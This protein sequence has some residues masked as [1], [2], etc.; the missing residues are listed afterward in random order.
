ML[1]LEEIFNLTEKELDIKLKEY[2]DNT[3]YSNL[4]DKIDAL[5][6]ELYNNS[7]LNKEELKIVG[8]P[9]YDKIMELKPKNYDEFVIFYNEIN[10]KPDPI[11]E[12]DLLT[13][14]GKLNGRSVKYFFRKF[15]K[16]GRGATGSVYRVQNLE[17]GTFYACKIME[18][19]QKLRYDPRNKEIQIHSK[20]QHENV[21]KM[22]KEY[23]T[24]D[25]INVY[26]FMELCTEVTWD[27][28]IPVRRTLS[29]DEIRK[30]TIQLINGLKYIH[31]MG[32]IHRDI[33]PQ[34]LLFNSNMELKIIDFGLA[35]S[36]ED[37]QNTNYSNLVGSLNYMSPEMIAD[38]MKYDYKVDIWALGILLYR[39]I[40]GVTP[41]QLKKIIDIKN[42]ITQDIIYPP[43]FNISSNLKN[44]IENILQKDQNNR[45]SLSQIRDHIFF[46]IEIMVE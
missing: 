12:E 18:Y 46:N 5:I 7:L 29:E 28:L 27:S 26:L 2:N 33:K 4:S 13:V 43:N 21:I 1:T 16:L 38:T 11:P 6:I 25:K 34:N 42:I 36:E 45:L 10:K 37:L 35:I 17:T 23:T 32:I 3:K 41:F 31:S 22:Y 44:L 9:N 14:P 8:N 39:S 30:Y 19:E 20:M 15:E 40:Y 24:T